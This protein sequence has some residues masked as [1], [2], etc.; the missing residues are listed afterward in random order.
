M[1]SKINTIKACKGT[2]YVIDG[3]QWCVGEKKMSKKYGLRKTKK[4][5]KNT[6]KKT[7]PKKKNRTNKSNK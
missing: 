6:N 2:I 4:N 1:N 3:K 5:R 7:N